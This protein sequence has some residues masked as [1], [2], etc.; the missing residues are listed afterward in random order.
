MTNRKR[1]TLA[2]VGGL[3]GLYLLYRLRL[4]RSRAL[5]AQRFAEERWEGEGG[6][7]TASS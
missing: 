4:A 7:T 1:I 6:A 5:G 3:A 2:L